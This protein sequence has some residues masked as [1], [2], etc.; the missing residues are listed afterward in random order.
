MFDSLFLPGNFNPN[1]KRYH[2]LWQHFKGWAIETEQP[3]FDPDLPTMFDFRTPQDGAMRF[4][5][6]LP[7]SKHKALV[8]YTLFSPTLLKD[9]AYDRALKQYINNI[10][11]LSVYKVIE[12]AEIFTTLFKK[13]SVF[14]MRTAP[15]LRPSRS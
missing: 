3:A 15:L 10:L 14:S 8:E 4:M 6:I 1:P 9:D 12:M 11:G 13:C 7:S 2:I 5:Y